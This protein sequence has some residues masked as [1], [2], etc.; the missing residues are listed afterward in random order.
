M[1]VCSKFIPDDDVSELT[2]TL[3]EVNAPSGFKFDK[4]QISDGGDH[5]SIT[6]MKNGDT[7]V[8]LYYEKFNETEVCPTLTLLKFNDVSHIK[9]SLVKVYDYYKL[10]KL[11]ILSI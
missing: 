5:L 11:I 10:S 8:V 1:K 4:S 3:I 2:Q 7:R 9:K 6:E